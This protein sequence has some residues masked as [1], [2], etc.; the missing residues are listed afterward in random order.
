MLRAPITAGFFV[1]VALSLAGLVSR[2][3]EA[4]QPRDGP[5]LSVFSDSSCPYSGEGADGVPSP[6]RAQGF[7]R[8]LPPGHPPVDAY[9]GALPPGHPPVEGRASRLPP[10]HPPLGRTRALPPPRFDGTTIVDL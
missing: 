4:S 2:P 9:G 6:G 10:G 7:E 3:V 1:L 5:A 8:A